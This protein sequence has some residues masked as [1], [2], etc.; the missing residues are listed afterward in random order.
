MKISPILNSPYVEPNRYF[1]SDERGLTEEIIE[2]RRPSTVQIPIAR[3]RG[4]A[5][6][7][8]HDP[9]AQAWS[10]ERLQ[11]NEFV[12]KLRAKVAEWR[13]AGY[14][15]TT[16][17]TRDLLRYWT[18]DTRE[19]R[20]FFCQVEAL[21]TL[22]YINEVAEKVGEHWIIN[23]LKR[24]NEDANSG[25]Y[26]LAFKLATGTGKTVVMAMIIAYNTLN[27]IRY[28]QDTRFTDTFVVVA[29]GITIRDRLNVLQP[30]N[31]HN[32]YRE[33]DIVSTTD[34]DELNRA[35]IL[36]VNFQQM[37]LRQNPRYSLGGVMKA[38]GL[39]NEAAIQETPE[40]MARRVF[41]QVAGKSRILVINDEAHHCYQEKPTDEKLSREE[42]AE[43]DENN[44]AARVWLEGLKTLA[45]RANVNGIV[46]LSAT[47]YFLSGS[48]YPEG[49]IFP[50]VVYDFSLLDALESGVVKIPRLPSADDR[51]SR[52]SMPEFRN[53]WLHIREELPAERL[54]GKLEVALLSL[55]GSY[56]KYYERYEEVKKTNGAVMPPVMIVVCNNMAVSKLVYEWIAGYEQQTA[57]G[58]V[59]IERGHLEHFRNEDGYALLDR[60]NT[61]LID[62]NRLESGESVTPEFKKSF[63]REIDEFKAEYRRR[64]A[65]R[66]EPTDEEILRE[67]MNTVGK[68]GRLGENIKCVV[69]VSMLTEGWDV[70]TVTH[71]LGVRAFSTQLLCEQVVGRALR[72][73]DYTPDEHG[74]FSAEYAEVY[75]VPFILWDSSGAPTPPPPPISYHHVKAL[76]ERAEKYEI[77]FPRVEGYHYEIDEEK[78]EAKFTPDSKTTIENETTKV[79]LEG[80]IGEGAE[81]TLEKIRER[82]EGTVSEIITTELLKRYYRDADGSEKYWLHPQLRRI[83]DTYVKTQ[84][85]L[86]DNMFI[87]YL[88]IGD[89]L[90]GAC[91]KIQHAIVT[92]SIEK[93][94]ERKL[95][96]VLSGRNPRGSTAGVDFLTTRPVFE[97]EKSHLNYVVADTEVWEQG[98]AKR[99]EEMDE[100][101]SYVKNYKLDF[102]IPYERN[103]AIHPYYPD[104]IV[105]LQLPGGG[106]LNLLI[107]VTGEK[108]QKKVSKVK[109]ANDLWV[110]AVNNHGGFGQWA[111]LE[112]RDIHE[113][114][115]LI[116]EEIRKAG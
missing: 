12:N 14:P 38:A 41:K 2:T 100:V 74:M 15:G 56:Q 16:R 11:E 101:I 96:P 88:S 53:L 7:E 97:T 37:V 10:S 18:D 89:Y 6:H 26:R 63:E 113:T 83:V 103:G 27:K 84:V 19:N 57:G 25:L 81:E 95:L 40:A 59:A 73:Q 94:G 22:I 107:E 102:T 24:F 32:Y 115:K 44:K 23:D 36:I 30:N 39:I 111:M 109:I 93:Q 42:K 71:I 9:A 60:P 98:V 43:A 50:W 99:L 75:G 64:F 46:D 58:R 20:L 61:L 108:D 114:Q 82:R 62:S 8:R 77:E 52:E 28:P 35:N 80:I 66:D 69:S 3:P 79:M 106:V 104:Y 13:K 4:R 68:P 33:R 45:S 54:P 65:G 110:P 55:Y 34:M 91:E 70:N 85:E 1:K 31:S 5:K 67:V 48:G 87:G 76:P 78:L 17:T 116:R 92:A 29:P 51:I 72:R 86:K 47:P 105:R 49:T 112:I 90:R 21:E